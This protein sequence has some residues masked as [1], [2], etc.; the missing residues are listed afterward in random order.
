[1]YIYTY[2]QL[3]LYI[4]CNVLED[5][6]IKKRRPLKKIEKKSKT[7]VNNIVTVSKVTFSK[8]QLS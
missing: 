8:N 4:C 2:E 6:D 7:H 3:S 1:M 5:E